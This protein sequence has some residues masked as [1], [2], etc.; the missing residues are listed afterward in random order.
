MITAAEARQLSG[1]TLD[2]KLEALG[3]SIKNKIADAR[4]QGGAAR[5]LRTGWEH[6]DD[7]EL[8]ID[9]GYSQTKEW[10]LAKQKLEELGYKVEFYYKESQFVDMYTHISW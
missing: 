1:R 9:G 5:G 10:L 7:R 2:E 6:P 3:E 8:W 4:K